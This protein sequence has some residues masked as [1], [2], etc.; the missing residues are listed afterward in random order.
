MAFLIPLAALQVVIA[1]DAIRMTVVSFPAVLLLVGN[2]FRVLTRPE[3]IAAT[4]LSAANFYSFNWDWHRVLV[5]GCASFVVVVW[6]FVVV[7]RRIQARTTV[8]IAQS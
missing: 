4:V 2:L 7:R 1:T 3:Q 6:Y 5:T 8:G